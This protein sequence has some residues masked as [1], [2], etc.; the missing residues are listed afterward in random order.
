[1]TWLS[2]RRSCR[3]AREKPLSQGNPKVLALDESIVKLP[4]VAPRRG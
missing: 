2:R 3:R 1:M 4:S